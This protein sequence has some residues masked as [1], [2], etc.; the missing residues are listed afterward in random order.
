MKKNS[1]QQSNAFWNIIDCYKLN[2]YQIVCDLEL[3]FARLVVHLFNFSL[4]IQTSIVTNDSNKM[5]PKR[6]LRL[7]CQSID[8]TILYFFLLVDHI[9]TISIPKRYIVYLFPNMILNRNW[10]FLFYQIL[11]LFIKTNCNTFYIQ[12]IQTKCT[13]NWIDL[14]DVQFA[15]I[16]LLW[17]GFN[18]FSWNS[19]SSLEE[20]RWLFI[21]NHVA[22]VKISEKSLHKMFENPLLQSKE[23]CT[24]KRN[25]R[26]HPSFTIFSL[27]IYWDTYL[28]SEIALSK[29]ECGWISFSFVD[30]WRIIIL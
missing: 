25:V 12:I 15:D 13:V 19:F 1:I 9:V 6:N 3:L 17:L 14:H 29:M 28:K 23:T 22:F 10:E 18:M 11:F 8:D 27:E 21:F 7:I 20:L 26:W 2:G 30:R 4:F 5:G 16:E 24:Y